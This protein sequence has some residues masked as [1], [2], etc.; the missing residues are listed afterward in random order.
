MRERAG[1]EAQQDRQIPFGL[2][3]L[4][5]NGYTMFDEFPLD[6]SR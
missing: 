2:A 5:A 3:G 4:G 6:K 1:A